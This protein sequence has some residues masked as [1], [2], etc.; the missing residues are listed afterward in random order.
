[1]AVCSWSQLHTCG[2]GETGNARAQDTEQ[3]LPQA[4]DPTPLGSSWGFFQRLKV[5]TLSL[6][7]QRQAPPGPPLGSCTGS[8]PGRP[9]CTAQGMVCRAAS[10]ST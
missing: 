5:E 8:V 4:P 6:G 9:M 7:E 2:S 1:M 3:F 10:V